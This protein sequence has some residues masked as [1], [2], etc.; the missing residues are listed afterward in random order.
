[1]A[2]LVVFHYFPGGTVVHRVDARFKLPLFL[3]LVAV[4]VHAGPFGLV[5]LCAATAAGV[6][7]ARLPAARIA[8]ELRLFLLLL[9]MM[10]IARSAG[11]TTSAGTVKGFTA[12]SFGAAGLLVWRLS[13]LVVL[14]TLLSATARAAHLQSA[15]AWYLRPFRFLPGGRIAMMVG[16]TISLIPLVFDSYREISDAQAA[17]GSHGL[18]QPIRRLKR[19][20][21]PLMLKTFGRA[22]EI[23]AAMESRC[24]TDERTFARLETG[25]ADWIAAGIVMLLAAA[26][27]GADHLR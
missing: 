19:V 16:L 20:V 22:N 17:R 14:G 5:L 3:L 27:I 15:V 4:A 21:V 13:L 24:Y 7:V 12:A 18:R 6:A 9:A 26:S 23:G 11:D 1:M 10:F 25:A 8:K 2:S